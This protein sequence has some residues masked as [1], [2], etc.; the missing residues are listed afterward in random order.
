MKKQFFQ[1]IYIVLFVAAAINPW[2]ASELI[3]QERFVDTRIY[4]KDFL[5]IYKKDVKGLPP[6]QPIPIPPI[7][8]QKPELMDIYNSYSAKTEELES[9]YIDYLT[10]KIAK[11][12]EKMNHSKTVWPSINNID[13][14]LQVRELEAVRNGDYT[15]P[16]VRSSRFL[17]Q[18]DI[19]HASKR[20]EFERELLALKHTFLSDVDA[21]VK[22]FEND[23]DWEFCYRLKEYQYQILLHQVSSD[24][25]YR[26]P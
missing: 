13:F 18:S 19:S 8:L 20:L 1:V 17:Y 26:Y 11:I 3:G 2:F 23:G 7:E 4:D 16:V 15:R 5:D 10:S 9:S 21:L 14:G 12:N 6:W 25:E 22:Q 24:Q